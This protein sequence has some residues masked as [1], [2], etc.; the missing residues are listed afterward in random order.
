MENPE[1]ERE[2][3]CAAQARK[4]SLPRVSFSVADLGGMKA[5]LGVMRCL[6]VS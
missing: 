4:E 1:L 5:K 3:A 6:W 2:A